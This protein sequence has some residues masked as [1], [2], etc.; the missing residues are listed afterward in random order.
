MVYDRRSGEVGRIVGRGSRVS[1]SFA[2]FLS[3]GN[4]WSQF[5]MSGFD[6]LV[7]VVLSNVSDGQPLQLTHFDA[8]HSLAMVTHLWT[9]Q[10]PNTISFQNLFS[11]KAS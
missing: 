11:R 3:F 8:F 5:Q 2:Q 7:A 1:N 6:L 4:V 9:K 10:P